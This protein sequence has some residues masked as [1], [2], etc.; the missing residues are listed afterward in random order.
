MDADLTLAEASAVLNP[1]MTEKQLRQI[2]RALGWQHAGTR[3]SGRAGHPPLTYD[4]ARLMAL[5][6]ALLPFLA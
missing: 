1:P 6:R 2:V 5:H 3:P 4:A